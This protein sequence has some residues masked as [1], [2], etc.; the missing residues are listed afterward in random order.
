MS[1]NL[2]RLLGHLEAFFPKPLT[3]EDWRNAKAFKWQHRQS[4][5]GSVG[6]LKPIRHL[7]DI[8]FDDL[9]SIE[10]QKE[11]I[12]NNTAHFAR[13]TMDPPILKIFPKMVSYYYYGMIQSIQTVQY[14]SNYPQQLTHSYRLRSTVG[15]VSGDVSASVVLPCR[16][17]DDFLSADKPPLGNSSLAGPSEGS[18]RSISILLFLN[19]AS[20][21]FVDVFFISDIHG[22]GLGLLSLTFDGTLAGSLYTVDRFC[23]LSESSDITPLLFAVGLVTGFDVD[24]TV[25]GVCL[26][27]VAAGFA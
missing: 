8:S 13:E 16:V 5:L 1:D 15:K 21:Q 23:S 27:T 18:L 24:V 12:M 14:H 20:I 17:N 22:G 9:Q 19:F 25:T 7:S 3:Q 26:A 11:A 6:F 10:R 4:I 2:E